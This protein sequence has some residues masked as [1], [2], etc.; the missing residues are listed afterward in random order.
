MG[1]GAVPARKLPQ[2]FCQILAEGELFAARSC[3]GSS[4]RER[5][6]PSTKL[7]NPKSSSVVRM[8]RTQRWTCGCTLAVHPR[9]R[10][11][12]VRAICPPM[13]RMGM[14]TG[15]CDED[16]EGRDDPGEILERRPP[17]AY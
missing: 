12:V 13:V 7:G 17:T 6:C 11:L 15:N 8:R 5:M 2:R 3:R 9:A 16:F 14:E 1:G 4:V 10:R